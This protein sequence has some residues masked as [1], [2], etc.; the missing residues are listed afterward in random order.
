M[1]LDWPLF[2]DEQPARAVMAE[3]ADDPRVLGAVNFAP[4]LTLRPIEG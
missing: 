4:R 2:V 1:L 3:V